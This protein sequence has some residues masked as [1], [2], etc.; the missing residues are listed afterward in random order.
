MENQ[1]TSALYITADHRPGLA[2]ARTSDSRRVLWLFLSQRN[3]ATMG[4]VRFL[5]VTAGRNQH[6]WGDLQKIRVYLVTLKS[7]SIH[8]VYKRLE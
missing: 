6:V 8:I 7:I 2:R 5:N 4:V 1:V 3:G